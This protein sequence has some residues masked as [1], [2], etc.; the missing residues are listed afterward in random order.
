MVVSIRPSRSTT[1]AVTSVW[2]LPRYAEM[3]R[4]GEIGGLGIDGIVENQDLVGT[5]DMV[6]GTTRRYGLR[7]GFGQDLGNLAAGRSGAKPW[8]TTASSMVGAITWTAI[9]A[10]AETSPDLAGRCKNESLRRVSIDEKLR[11]GTATFGQEIDHCGGSFLDRP[12]GD[13]DRRPGIT[14]AEPSH[15][16]ELGMDRVAIDIEGLAV[17]VQRPG[18]RLRRI[19]AI[20]SALASRPTTTIRP[21]S[22]RSSGSGSSP[23]TSGMLAVRM[24]RL[25]R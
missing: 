18:R 2:V 19:W 20:R 5:D 14:G 9:P 25:A 22:L 11:T 1:A 10:V 13:V 21:S 24:P 3:A 16:D 17:F 7:L 23:G 8:R 4:F 12:A 15:L 6:I